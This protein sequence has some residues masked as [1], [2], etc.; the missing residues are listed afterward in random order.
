MFNEKTWLAFQMLFISMHRPVPR[1]YADW[2]LT[3]LTVGGGTAGVVS[4]VT[5]LGQVHSVSEAVAL[6]SLFLFYAI[7]MGGGVVRKEYPQRG[8]KLCQIFFLAQI[9][10][11]QT[12]S[13]SYHISALFSYAITFS[14]QQL[15]LTFSWFF[16][17]DWEFSISKNVTSSFYGVNVIPI[18]ALMLNRL[19]SARGGGEPKPDVGEARDLGSPPEITLPGSGL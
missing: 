16:G 14:P 5:A 4:C 12:S 17:S 2:L 13:I 18:A 3:I 15:D 10:V 7:G 8:F 9:P 1:N 11:F 6:G 19:F